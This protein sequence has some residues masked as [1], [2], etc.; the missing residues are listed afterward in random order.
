MNGEVEPPPKTP[1]SKSPMELPKAVGKTPAKPNGDNQGPKFSEALAFSQEKAKAVAGCNIQA[2]SNLESRHGFHVSR[3][4]ALRAGL[5]QGFIV[6]APT[7]PSSAA[8]LP[9]SGPPGS[10]QLL[11]PRPRT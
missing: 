5:S 4:P 2:A 6:N 1:E 7:S 8:P 10:I 3:R 11:C 9:T